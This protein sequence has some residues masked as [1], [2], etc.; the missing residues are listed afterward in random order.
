MNNKIINLV[1]IAFIITS[2]FTAVYIQP[3]QAQT[4][5]LNFE[6]VTYYYGYRIFFDVRADDGGYIEGDYYGWVITIT[7]VVDDFQIRDWNSGEYKYYKTGTNINGTWTSTMTDHTEYFAFLINGTNHTVTGASICPPETQPTNTAT[8]SGPTSTAGSPTTGITPTSAITS[9]PTAIPLDAG[10]I[11][12]AKNE[13]RTVSGDMTWITYTSGSVCG[14]PDNIDAIQ[15]KINNV[16][17]TPDNLWG[18]TLQSLSSGSVNFYWGMPGYTGEST[19]NFYF[20]YPGNSLYPLPYG[21]ISAVLSTG[22]NPESGKYADGVDFSVWQYNGGSRHFEFSASAH[23]KIKRPPLCKPETIRQTFDLAMLGEVTAGS[24]TSRHIS[25]DPAPFGL[26]QIDV[27]LS[28]TL[29][30]PIS[31][32][33]D[34]SIATLIYTLDLAKPFQI[35]NDAIISI[36]GLEYESTQ[37]T[38]IAIT[39]GITQL[40]VHFVQSMDA[41]AAPAILDHLKFTVDVQNKDYVL[42]CDGGMELGGTNDSYETPWQ[43]LES[44]LAFQRLGLPGYFPPVLDGGP[45]CGNAFQEIGPHFSSPIGAPIYEDFNVPQGGMIYWKFRYRS[46]DLF[47]FFPASPQFFVTNKQTQAD[48][49]IFGNPGFDR[50]LAVRDWTFKTG[51]VYLETGDYTIHLD[52][53][54]PIDG[55][56]Y[57]DDVYFGINPFDDT[58]TSEI[59]KVQKADPPASPTPTMTGSPTLTGTLTPGTMTATLLATRTI[60]ATSTRIPSSTSIGTAGTFSPSVTL[61]STWTVTATKTYIPGYTP[62]PGPTFTSTYGVVLPSVTANPTN[63]QS[64]PNPD[65]PPITKGDG[66]IGFSGDSTVDCMRPSNWFSVAW[67]LDYERCQVISFIT[68]G[69]DQRSTAVAIPSIFDRYEP[70]GTAKEVAEGIVSVRTEVASYEWNA[71]GAAAGVNDSINPLQP[72]KGGST[73]SDPWNGNLNLGADCGNPVAT[74]NDGCSAKIQPYMPGALANGTCFVF[75]LTRNIGMLPW[76]QFFINIAALLMPIRTAFTIIGM[77]NQVAGVVSVAAP[78]TSGRNSE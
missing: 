45:A 55:A 26:D 59:Y 11:E 16:T 74:W 66:P 10:W 15:I 64:T 23:C 21:S 57:Y 47:G 30:S 17:G 50:A 27:N 73:C 37:F 76:L 71:S 52:G 34:Y 31:G 1:V 51:S 41:D 24:L 68:F 28:Y 44:G 78:Y 38:A 33:T 67:W 3:V 58:C 40:D 35:P 12:I 56:I 62:G 75:G 25:N 72:L 46:L 8:S 4:S 20:T 36:N 5:C 6:S 48:T 43:A 53:G 32:K 7:G 63:S 39:T 14:M 70:F 69:P 54:Y 22:F 2:S 77:R 13:S 18:L 9:I 60:I 19:G 42:N 61:R 29:P 49:D 65:L